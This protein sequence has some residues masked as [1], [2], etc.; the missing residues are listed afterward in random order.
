M[1]YFFRYPAVLAG[2]FG[3]F[4]QENGIDHY[5]PNQL[6]R[7]YFGRQVAYLETLKSSVVKDITYQL[8]QRDKAMMPPRGRLPKLW[9]LSKY[10]LTPVLK[11]YGTP[12]LL[13]M[14]DGNIGAERLISN[15]RAQSDKLHLHL[16]AAQATI[17]VLEQKVAELEQKIG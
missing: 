11:D 4:C 12:H 9:Y 2:A 14:E 7:C 8:V 13:L 3:Q 10:L 15:L 16:H 5:N 1:R 6:V 17:E